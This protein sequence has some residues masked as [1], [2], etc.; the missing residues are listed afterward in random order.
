[1]VQFLILLFLVETVY[2]Y[3]NRLKLQDYS[4]IWK[5]LFLLYLKSF[6]EITLWVYHFF[7][8]DSTTPQQKKQ[9]SSEE[10]EWIIKTIVYPT[11]KKEIQ[12][13]KNFTDETR[14]WHPSHKEEEQEIIFKRRIA[15]TEEESLKQEL[16]FNRE[17]II[18]Y[19]ITIPI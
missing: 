19:N 1:M 6:F 2:V 16:S 11:M 17:H 18:S 9:I 5:G 7:A 10:I 8:E 14:E 12:S 13:I 4:N 3:A 15:P